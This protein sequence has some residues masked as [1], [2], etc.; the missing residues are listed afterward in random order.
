MRAAVLS[1]FLV[2]ATGLAAAAT[3]EIKRPVG[4]PQA[5]GVTHLARAIP[6]ACAWLEGTFTGDAAS[7]YKFVPVR[8]SPTCQARARLLNPEKA[9]PSESTGWKLNDVVRIPSKDCPGLQAVVEIWR[10]PSDGKS[11]QLDAQG[12]ARLYLQD[13]KANAAKAAPTPAYTAKVAI[14][15]KAC[16]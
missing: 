1:S 12:R 8:S 7:P 9:K 10:L 3:P 11:M 6:E 2:L 4:A 16:G 15:G 5:N 13:A 14:E